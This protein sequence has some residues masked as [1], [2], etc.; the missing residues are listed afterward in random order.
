MWRDDWCRLKLIL[1][2]PF[3]IVRRC[4]T[5]VLMA[6]NGFEELHGCDA[7]YVD[8]FTDPSKTIQLLGCVI[9]VDNFISYFPAAIKIDLPWT[10]HWLLVVKAVIGERLS[11][12]ICKDNSLTGPT[13]YPRE[14]SAGLENLMRTLN[15]EMIGQVPAIGDVDAIHWRC[16]FQVLSIPASR[17]LDFLFERPV[18]AT[19]WATRQMKDSSSGCGDRKKE[20][21]T[22]M[23][24][25]GPQ[26]RI[27]CW[28]TR[29]MYC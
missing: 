3:F 20:L 28:A 4:E 1:S 10:T 16:H 7:Q 5:L 18:S 13:S 27:F 12:K 29:D 11:S 8:A 21:A 17:M 6:S 15:D 25:H 9:L 24:S 26:V 22:H 2:N 23:V 19:D 14:T